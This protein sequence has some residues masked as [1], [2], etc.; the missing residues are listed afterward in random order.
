M[1]K[2]TVDD[3]RDRINEIMACDVDMWVGLMSGIL[4][5]IDDSEYSISEAADYLG[6]TGCRVALLVMD[7]VIP[8]HTVERKAG[9]VHLGERRIRYADLR[10]YKSKIEMLS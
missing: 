3:V 10:A 8:Y 5:D 4:E 6:M 2:L 7:G 9:V 1:P